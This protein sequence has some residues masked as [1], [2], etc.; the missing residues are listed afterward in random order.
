MSKLL[1]LGVYL[2]NE[3]ISEGVETRAGSKALRASWLCKT[4]RQI[5]AMAARTVLTLS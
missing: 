3:V 4:S 2:D 5:S 1:Q